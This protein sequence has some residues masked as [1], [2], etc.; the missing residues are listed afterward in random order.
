MRIAVCDAALFLDL[1]GTLAPIMPSPDAVGPDDTRR[2]LLERAEKALGGRLAVVSGRA[3][4]DL[5]RILDGVPGALAGLHGLERRAAGEMAHR[6]TPP[7][8]YPQAVVAA[9]AFVADRPTI[10]LEDKG[11]SLALHW[12]A[13]PALGAEVGA[14]AEALAATA[15]L[16]AQPGDMVIELRAPGPTKG[17]ALRAFM[18]EA[19]F[20]SAT[21][22]FV[23]DDLTDEHGFEAATA[24]GGAGVL[25]GKPRPTRAASRLSEPA[26]VLRWIDTGLAQGAFT[27][28]DSPR[29]A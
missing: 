17:D 2:S 24:L 20:A 10:L 29:A 4:T 19:P 6:P 11:L 15:G 8:G 26:A 12:R 27:L 3:I 1:D 25:V 22:I 18:A 23:G 13:A 7:P 28:E 14:F 5:E 16:V 9:R 21:P